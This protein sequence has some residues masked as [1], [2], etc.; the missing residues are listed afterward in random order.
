MVFGAI[1]CPPKKSRKV[2]EESVR[3]LERSIFRC[4]VGLCGLCRLLSTETSLA[5]GGL[6]FASS[7]EIVLGT[8]TQKQNSS[9][10]KVSLLA[11]EAQLPSK[12]PWCGSLFAKR[13][14]MLGR[15]F[16]ITLIES[17]WTH[18]QHGKK[19]FVIPTKSFV[20][21]RITKIFCYNKMFGSINKTFGCCGKF[22][23]CSNKNLTCCP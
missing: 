6:T 12:R 1:E 3:L 15:T 23:G 22:F 14:K 2:M 18:N 17:L 9:V 7:T 11:N 10:G 19:S 21:I 13:M 5:S 20:K 8:E 16:L 4:W